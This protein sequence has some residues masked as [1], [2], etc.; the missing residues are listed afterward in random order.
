MAISQVSGNTYDPYTLEPVKTG[1]NA[2]DRNA[3]LSLLITQLQYQDP[4]KPMEDREFIAQLAQFSSLEQMTQVND[5]LGLLAVGSA[6]TQATGYLGRTVT[7]QTPDDEQP[8]TGTVSAVKYVEGVPMLVIGERE[9][10]PG[11]V[12]SVK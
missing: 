5:R 1:E 7:A 3:F 4:M 6:I 10:N 12:L 9:V 2:L 11:Y 8:F